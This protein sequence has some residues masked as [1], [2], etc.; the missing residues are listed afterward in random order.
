MNNIKIVCVSAVFK[1]GG[2]TYDYLVPSDVTV[3]PK[4]DDFILTSFQ[5]PSIAANLRHVQQPI[6]DLKYAQITKVHITPTDKAKKTFLKLI[7]VDE[8]KALKK[9][10]ADD[11]ATIVAKIDARKKLR[12]MLQ[13][14]AE[15]EMFQ[16]LAEVNPEAAALVELLKA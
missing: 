11:T 8:L 13:G 16:K 14:Q 4:V 6:G 12:E 1:D 5:D 2:G 10:Q 15:L 7:P 9:R 3:G